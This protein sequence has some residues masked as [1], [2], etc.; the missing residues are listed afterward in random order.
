MGFPML[1]YKT[2]HSFQK[3]AIP[4]KKEGWGEG[5]KLIL[6]TNTHI[7]GQLVLVL[8]IELTREVIDP[9]GATQF[10]LFNHLINSSLLD[11]Y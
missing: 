11:V 4:R 3:L 2:E 10:K 9:N 1:F 5:L 6:P 8:N 7:L